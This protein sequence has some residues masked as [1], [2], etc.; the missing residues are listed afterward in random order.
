MKLFS[1]PKG[2][3]VPGYKEK[4]RD[5][6]IADGP[7]AQELVFPMKMHTGV[8]AT[9]CVKVGDKVKVGTLI[10]KGRGYISAH[11]HSSVSGRVRCIE[12]RQSFRGKS[13]AVVV[14]NDRRDEE[15]RLEPLEQDTTPEKFFERLRDAGL[16]GKGGA[17]FPTHVKLNPQNSDGQRRI[18]INGVECESYSTTDHRVILEYPE[19]ILRATEWMRRLFHARHNVIAVEDDK[20]DAIERLQRT[21]NDLHYRDIEIREVKGLYPQGDQG[22]LYRTVFGREIPFGKNPNDIG[23]LTAN[24]STVK[25]VYD[26]VFLGRPLVER[27]I[28]VTGP[29]IAEPQNVL[30]RIGTPVREL[31][32]F[33][34]GLRSEPGKLVNGGL[35]MGRPFNDLNIPVVKDTTTILCM[36][37]TAREL[38][39]ERPCIRCAKCVDVCPVNLQPVLISNA[40]RKGRIG[41]CRRLKATTCIRCGCCTYICPSK[42][43]LLEDI[44]SAVAEI[45]KGEKEQESEF[46]RGD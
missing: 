16:T 1:P 45:D 39:Q 27:V 36:D 32:A 35:M 24:V 25:A 15:E 4:T 46:G 38:P 21:A 3:H 8:P 23:L 29:A 28:T 6:P 42:I 33:C 18:L 30:S 7:D 20:P 34:G 40:W 37:A 41:R 31:I 11:I 5:M 44:Q 26:A 10:G 43:P 19:E 14:D 9:A 22:T 2:V 17:G 13:T 12:E